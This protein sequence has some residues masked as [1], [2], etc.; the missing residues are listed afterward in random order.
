[1]TTRFATL[2]EITAWNEHVISNPDGG[3]ILQGKE[4]IGQKA[5][6]GWT[7]RYLFV[8]QRAIAM[9]EKSI[10]L[11]GKV[12]YCPKGPSTSSV[13]DL[14]SLI[15]QI[16][17][18]AKSQGVFTVKIEPELDYQTDVS[19]LA[20]IPT[21]PIQY[22]YSTVYVDLHPSLD[23]IM[24][25]LNQKGRHAIRRA[26][27][28]GVTVSA[29]EASDENCK[30]MYDL[31]LETA[32]GAGFAIRQPEYYRTFYRAYEKVGLGRLFF[33]YFDGKVVAGAFAMV[34]GSKSMYKDGAS[35]RE[36]TAYGASHLLQ[37][38]VIQWA[39][40]LG[41]LSHDLAGVPPIS[42]IKN[43]DH[44]FSGLARFKTSFN[45]EVTQYVGAFEIPVV[46]WKARLWHSFVE[47]LVR[48]WHFKRHHESYY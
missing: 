44:P 12:W 15:K 42:E 18:F 46:G 25:S 28:D 11:L 31:F 22:N 8:N 21:T 3:N 47:K 38:H 17:A 5:L 45:K 7:P 33:A 40:S 32:G 29:V 6:G 2:D 26:E 36:R 27:R 37:W 13:N 34:Q 1:M 30:I 19:K 39:K 4:F 24:A 23:E 43:P 35:V 20:L 14:E 10:P 41:S 9:I 48:R 16:S